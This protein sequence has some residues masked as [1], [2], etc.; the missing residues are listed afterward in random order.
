MK[1]TAMVE[2]LHGNSDPR[3][4]IGVYGSWGKEIMC[5]NSSLCD[6][7]NLM[8]LI[9]ISNLDQSGGGQTSKF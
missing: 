4:A 8:N 9:E 6:F 1:S 3:D 7:S 2:P 5:G